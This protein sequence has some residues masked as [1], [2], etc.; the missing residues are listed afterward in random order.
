MRKV[1]I[2]VM[3]TL[4]VIALSSLVATTL[5]DFQYEDLNV[6]AFTF[7]AFAILNTFFVTT[8]R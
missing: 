5:T 6:I 4:W 1:L 2:F 8:R 3:Y 7:L